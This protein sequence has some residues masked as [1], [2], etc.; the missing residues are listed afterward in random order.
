MSKTEYTPFPE[1]NLLGLSDSTEINFMESQGLMFAEIET[2]AL[3][4]DAEITVS[5]ILNLHKKAFGK[6][7][8]WAGKWRKETVN[9]GNFIP[10][11]PQEVPNLFYQFVEEVNFKQKNIQEKIDLLD[12]LAYTHHRFVYIHPFTNGNGRMARL[13]MNLIVMLKGY[14]PIQLYFR[15][16][17]DREIYI[18]AIKDADSGNYEPLRILIEK[19]LFTL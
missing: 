13:V 18:K 17:K 5:L 19:E 4:S 16:G 2:I 8:E 10:P 9:V 12:L 3:E 15:E 1:D 11:M 14:K 6:L 7:Y